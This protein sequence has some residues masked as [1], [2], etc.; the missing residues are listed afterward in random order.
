VIIITYS[1]FA[2]RE[3]IVK[4]PEMVIL[5]LHEKL[6]DIKE[7]IRNRKSRNQRQYI[8]QKRKAKTTNKDY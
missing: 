4:M 1:V 6:E 2:L 5:T 7:I 3:L 8:G